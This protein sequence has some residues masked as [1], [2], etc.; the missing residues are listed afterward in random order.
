MIHDVIL[1][2]LF[3]ENLAGALKTL[4]TGRMLMDPKDPQEP[5]LSPEGYLA[6]RIKDVDPIVFS[7]ELER[8]VSNMRIIK[9][10]NRG[11]P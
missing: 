11:A 9:V 8:R 3:E 6:V 1:D 5:L 4:G 7:R 10:V 2:T